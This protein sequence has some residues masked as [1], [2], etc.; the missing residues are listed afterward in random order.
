[1]PDQAEQTETGKTGKGSNTMVVSGYGIEL[2]GFAPSADG[3]SNPAL[4]GLRG[5]CS[6]VMV[7]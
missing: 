7:V 3:R 4:R 2:L 1:V 5:S 6:R